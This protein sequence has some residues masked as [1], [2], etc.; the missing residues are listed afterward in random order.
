LICRVDRFLLEDDSE[1]SGGFAPLHFVPKEKIVAL[2]LVSSKH[3]QIEKQDDRLRRIAAAAQ[4]VP[5][6]QLALS[7]Q[8]GFAS[9]YP[10]A[11]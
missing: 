11:G 3:G 6:E 10:T 4:Y 8:C 9:H 2:R 1:R 5:Y 7:P